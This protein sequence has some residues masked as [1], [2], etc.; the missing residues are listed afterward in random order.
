MTSWNFYIYRELHLNNNL[1]RVL[2]FEL[3]KLFQLQTL[4][5]KGMISRICAAYGLHVCLWRH[6]RESFCQGFEGSFFPRVHQLVRCSPLVF[7]SF[8][9]IDCLLVL[10]MFFPPSP[11]LLFLPLF[12]SPLCFGDTFLTSDFISSCC[13]TAYFF[14]FNVQISKNGDSYKVQKT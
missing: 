2:P 9:L 7:F 13:K 3:G 14:F 11:A 1:L 10:L 12:Q 4:G 5:L 6:K 8:S